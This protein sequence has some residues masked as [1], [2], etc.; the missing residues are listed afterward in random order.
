[1]EA[2]MT[3]VGL[4]TPAAPVMA[5]GKS[6]THERATPRHT[7]HP[8]K[9]GNEDTTDTQLKEKVITGVQPHSDTLGKCNTPGQVAPET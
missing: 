6:G 8:D 3:R 1:M 5:R 9:N 7:W 2:P 4:N